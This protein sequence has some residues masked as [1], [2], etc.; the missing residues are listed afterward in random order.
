MSFPSRISPRQIVV[1]IFEYPVTEVHV[2]RNVSVNE[3]SISRQRSSKA[4]M[5]FDV[6]LHLVVGHASPF[7]LRFHVVFLLQAPA[8]YERVWMFFGRG[9]LTMPVGLR[10]KHLGKGKSLSHLDEAIET[11]P[12]VDVLA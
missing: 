12:D 9:D 5:G 4:G 8:V 1:L 6:P 3:S 7:I 2:S 10:F 11:F